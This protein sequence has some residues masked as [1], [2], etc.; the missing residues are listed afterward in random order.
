MPTTTTTN[1]NCAL[2]QIVIVVLTYSCAVRSW[3]LCSN[4]T[5]NCKSGSTAKACHCDELCGLMGDCCRDYD[6]TKW[7]A[8]NVK[9]ASSA[10]NKTRWSADVL[11]YRGHLAC[12]NYLQGNAFYKTSTYLEVGE[13]LY[14]RT[15]PKSFQRKD[16]RVLCEDLN[17]TDIFLNWFVTSRTTK[18][19]Y[20][21][22]FCSQCWNDTNVFHWKVEYYCNNLSDTNQNIPRGFPD[23][24]GIKKGFKCKGPELPV[25][26]RPSG[27]D[28][29]RLPPGFN[30][31]NSPGGP[32]MPGSNSR[33]PPGPKPKPQGDPGSAPGYMYVGKRSVDAEQWPLHRREHIDMLKSDLGLRE[34]PPPKDIYKREHFKL[35]LNVTPKRQKRTS[36]ESKT[37]Y[38]CKPHFIYPHCDN[39]R[40]CSALGTISDC[41]ERW[42]GTTVE[43]I[44]QEGSFGRMRLTRD[45]STFR[46]I[47][48]VVCN[49]LNPEH[50]VCSYNPN[51][52][53]QPGV[54][55][56]RG[57]KP[58]PLSMIFDPEAGR[59]VKETQS[60]RES[61]PLPNCTTTQ[62][63]DIFAY[64]C[65]DVSCQ[66]GYELV[67]TTCTKS[68][69]GVSERACLWVKFKTGEFEVV[70]KSS[71]VLIT[72]HRVPLTD[73]A[74]K[75]LTNASVLICDGQLPFG[76]NSTKVSF[77]YSD[78]TVV[79]SI[80][81]QTI[82]MICLLVQFI[83]YL[84]L[85]GLRNTPGLTIMSLVVALFYAQFLLLV[86]GTAAGQRGG[87]VFIAVAIHYFFLAS[88]C[89]MCCLAL[90]LALTFSSTMIH[91][92][93]D[94]AK[95]C[96]FVK[97]SIF[98]WLSPLLVVLLA[99]ITDAGQGNTYPFNP[100]YGQGFCWITNKHGLYMWFLAPVAVL[101]TASL[102]MYAITVYKIVEATK[103]ASLVRKVDKL[104]LFLY[105]KLAVIM[106][107]TW[108]LAFIWVGTKSVVMEYFFIIFNSLQGAFIFV[109]FVCRKKVYRLLKHKLSKKKAIKSKAT[110]TSRI[111]SSSGMRKSAAF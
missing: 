41:K 78:G 89:W 108:V 24:R 58:P 51:T 22:M 92:G 31:G 54:Y 82:S 105:I 43:K 71:I 25:S 26:G 61:V 77:S 109:A 46:N 99:L 50:P 64:R 47:D 94:H 95:T 79:T 1:V 68:K 6:N 30:S 67:S 63:L 11:L 111:T 4:D 57:T 38:D 56:A 33:P 17:S 100:G 48:C 59:L 7:S 32:E 60:M 66:R 62:M 73:S 104:N 15:C 93:D 8:D 5:L 37:Q 16:L 45:G 12:H 35:A 52:V 70:N 107:L 42:K 88:F 55:G 96:R 29:G 44:C 72:G 27:K 40:P 18:V 91:R 102:T 81:L 75:N 103:A 19:T 76:W 87:C 80:L 74:V 84:L 110:R 83:V 2:Y 101:L 9:L 3:D 39:L 20:R 23:H 10:D 13:F 28:P 21:N 36:F 86:S 49:G 14:V 85:P 106:G 34:I 90:D 53:Q 97:F 98:G 65:R 69:D